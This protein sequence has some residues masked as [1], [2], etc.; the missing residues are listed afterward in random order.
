VNEPTGGDCLIC[1]KPVPDYKPM[2]CC[3]G[4]DCNCM[5]Q[6]ME[7]CLCSSECAIACYDGIGKSYEQRRIDAGIAKWEPK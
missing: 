2:L 6:P 7:P 5:G 3:S 4:F 1:D